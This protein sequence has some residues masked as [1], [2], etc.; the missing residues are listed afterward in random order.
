MTRNELAV[1]V[2]VVLPLVGGALAWLAPW[3]W[4]RSAVVWLT[5]GLSAAAGVYAVTLLPFSVTLGSWHEV[6][7]VVCELMLVGLVAYFAWDERGWLIVGLCAVQVGVLIFEWLEGAGQIPVIKDAVFCLDGLAGALVVIINVIGG[8]IL[9]YATGYMK[10]H[11]CHGGGRGAREGRFFLVLT[12]FLGL[13]NGLVLANH[14]GWLSVFWEGTTL[15]SFLLI[16]HEGTPEARGNAR[17]ALLINVFG[18]VVMSLAGVVAQRGGAES[19]E[20]VLGSRLTVVFVLLCIAALAKSAQFPLQ[21]WLLGAMVAPTPV[22]A[23]LHSA[24]MVKAGAYLVLRLAPAFEGSAVMDV[25][26]LIGGFSFAVAAALAVSQSNAKRVLAYS[27]ISNLGL[28]VACAGIG[29]P[30]AYAAALMI[31]CFHAASKGLL[32]L[33]VGAIEQEIGSRDIEDMGSLLH[34]M[35]LT[36]GVTIAGMLT[37]LVPPFGM[38]MSKLMAIEAAIEAPLVVLLVIAGSALTVFFW[39]KW[40]GRVQTVSYHARYRLER[41]PRSMMGVLVV[42]CAMVLGGGLGSLAIY[43]QVIEPMALG[44]FP[45]AAEKAVAALRAAGQLHSWPILVFPLLAV[46]AWLVTVWRFNPGYVRLPYLA[47]ENRDETELS[48]KFTSVKDE[49]VVAWA[50]SLYFRRTLNEERITPWANLLAWLL[51]LS[52]LGVLGGR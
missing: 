43:R 16:R 13:M 20:G 45:H 10:V 7:A 21:S 30:L 25:I 14:L 26:A 22:S 29:T 32:F 12:G 34:T 15:C 18:G 28:I 52:L 1:A 2:L 39:A 51:V 33:C 8:L 17:R 3:R 49:P 40:I 42:L 44:A 5:A 11:S 47:G 9:V 46:I 19:L 50:T 23:L 6:V 36:A 24:T 31:V 41:M 35:P 4:L 48:Y 37:M 38:L 27:T